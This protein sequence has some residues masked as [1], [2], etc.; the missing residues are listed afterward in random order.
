MDVFTT[1]PKVSGTFG[2]I[3]STHWLASA[4]GMAVLEKGGN[5]F[6]AAAAAGFVLQVVEP[7]QNGPGGEVPIILKAANEDSPVVICGQ[8]VSPKL[9]TLEKFASLGLRMVP[10]TGMLPAVVPGAF[11]AWM[12]MLREYGT[13]RPADI[14]GYA[15]HY[16]EHG[17]PILRRT[18]ATISPVQQRFTSDWP[19]SAEVWLPQG[20]PPAPGALFRMPH[21]AITFKRILSEAAAAGGD[22]IRQIEAARNAF[23]RGFVAESI[24]RFYSKVELPDGRGQRHPGLLRGEDLASWEATQE[25]TLSFDYCGVT[26]HKTG[27]WGQ[28]PMCLQE[29]ALLKNFDL[30]AMD[31]CGADF[32][33]TVIES[34]KL[35]LA[36]R[37]VFY[38]DPLHFDVPIEQ[39][40][41]DNY[42]NMRSKLVG[43]SASELLRPGEMDSSKD[44]LSVLAELAGYDQPIAIDYGE[45]VY[46]DLPSDPGDTCYL[47]VAD[48]HGNMVSATPSGGWLQGSPV[49]PGLGFS[50]TTR[51]QMFWLD[52]RLPSSLRPRARPRTTLSPT[53]VT[54]DAEA[55]LAFGA[56]GGDW[57]GQW[58]L[59]A[60][61]RY[62]HHNM[63][64]Q[65]AIE[66]PNFHCQHYPESFYPR[67]LILGQ[68]DLE[69]RFPPAAIEELK[70][71]G[72][73]VEVK[74]EWSLG[75]VCMVERQYGLLSAAASPRQVQ[76]YAI[77]R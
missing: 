67:K 2:A 39:L 7:H 55:E 51:G 53:L 33:H 46:E 5:A 6:D 61:L 71:R 24:D 11:D 77:C 65:K 73:K 44:R 4:T 22:R 58:P 10:G 43:K 18:V 49:V 63:N 3:A 62:V 32:V 70:Q 28:G 60:F 59:F 45:P 74:P 1:R 35:A 76:A 56:P 15:I 9:A 26:V 69:A 17:Y 41:S 21:L 52:D 34:A 42:N 30:A 25:T 8:G 23:Y 37:D 13:L 38:G 19:S 27:P 29:L 68:T 66:A 16:A 12:L 48:Q 75:R 20:H 57:Q 47:C 40:L 14:L 64:I 31:P 36:D 54:R 50:V 72:H